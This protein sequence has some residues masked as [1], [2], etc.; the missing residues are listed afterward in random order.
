VL[1]LLVRHGLTDA[2][3]RRLSGQAPGHHLSEAGREQAAALVRRMEPIPLAAIYASP[4]ERC[5]E[6][7][8]PLARARRTEVR[9]L[10]GVLE[11]GY[12][13]WT[14]RPLAQLARTDLWR[15]V[16]QTPSR[17]R[18][19]DGE[20]LAEVQRRSVEALEDLAPRHRRRAVAVVTHADV[21]RLVLAH[22]AGVHLDLYQR[23]VVSP[24]SVSAVALGDG[25][26]RILRMND[27]GQLGD[28]APRRSRRAPASP[29][30][31]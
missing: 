3:G 16:Q 11:V 29:H 2:T 21:I 7:A 1:L 15:R 23:L 9:P 6:T 8:E 30:R 12:G 27:T 28:L 20:S 18:F 13:R 31:A 25:V 4:L 19:P 5:V 22:Y 10:P 24:A 14:G 17:V 26:P